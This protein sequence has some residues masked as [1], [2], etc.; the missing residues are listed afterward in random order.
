M[1]G[2]SRG[3]IKLLS[4]KQKKG[5]SKEDSSKYKLLRSGLNLISEQYIRFLKELRENSDLIN[6]SQ[7]VSLSNNLK[8]DIK[9]WLESQ[10]DSVKQIKID[11]KNS[12][13]KNLLKLKELYDKILNSN[14]CSLLLGNN[15]NLKVSAFELFSAYF[16][17][18]QENLCN[19]ITKNE[20]EDYIKNSKVNILIKS[21]N[22]SFDSRILFEF[23]NLH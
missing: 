8:K 11:E 6:K 19:K 9:K 17:F 3:Y 13:S 15:I 14:T 7:L 5:F 4:R 16:E 21:S 18:I 22:S 20:I 23:I 1:D 10:I 12:Q 2:L